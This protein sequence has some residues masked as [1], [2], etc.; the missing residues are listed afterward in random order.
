[1]PMVFKVMTTEAIAHLFLPELELR[2]NPLFTFASEMVWP[3][4]CVASVSVRLA[5]F[6]WTVGCKLWRC[7]ISL[8][9][10]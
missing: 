9:Q 5:H 10:A 8:L 1:M 7:C 2:K 6:I 4:G 3:F